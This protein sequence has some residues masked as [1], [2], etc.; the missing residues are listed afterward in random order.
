MTLK[1]NYKDIIKKAWSKY[2]HLSDI[3][4]IKD[5]S[6]NV[7][8]N[9][10]FIISLKNNKKII[11]K[12]SDYGYFNHFLEDHEIINSL[13]LNLSEPFENFL[14][15]SLTKNGSLF[16][17]NYENKDIRLWVVFYNPIKIQKKPNKLQTKNNI[18][19]LGSELAK[20]HLACKDVTKTLPQ[21]FKQTRDD[22][23][24]LQQNIKN[25]NKLQF[26]NKQNNLI[27]SQCE[28]YLSNYLSLKEKAEPSIPVFIDWNIGNFS[29]TKDYKFFSRWDYDWFRIG[30]R[31]LDFYFFSR[32]CSYKGDKTFFSYLPNSLNEERFIIFLKS[33]HKIYPLK[34]NEVLLMKEMY[35]FFILN[36]VIK[37]GKLFFHSKLAKRLVAESLEIYIPNIDNS[38]QENKIL[39]RLG[40]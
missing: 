40:L 29:L 10:V 23:R 36:Y 8:T 12:I 24:N 7:S 38:F 18:Q 35:R 17:F 16:T 19:I 32:V 9:N 34:K 11:A 39:D 33:Y 21:N 27:L 1:V 4:N 6:I 20:F 14:A 31:I 2:G 28:I 22:I 5:I 37:D 15:K 13:S 3:S 26:S 30:T 25:K